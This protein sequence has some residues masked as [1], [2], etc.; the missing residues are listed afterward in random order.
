MF[1]HAIV[2]SRND[3]GTLAL[4]IT[5]VLVNHADVVHVLNHGSSDQTAHGLKVLQEIWGKR[6][7]IY[8]A[9]PDIPF[10]QSLLTNMLVPIAENEGADWIYVFDSD[11]FL[12]SKPDFSLK[13]ELSKLSSDTVAARYNLSNYISTHD[14]D[15]DNISHYQ[16]LIYKSKPSINCDPIRSMEL[17]SEGKIS[18]FD[19]TF[20]S[21]IFFRANKDLLIAK[22]AHG[23]Q[24][25]LDKQSTISFIDAECAHLSLSSKK[26]LS[27]KSLHGKSLIDLGLSKKLGWQNQLVHQLDIAG[28]LD[29]FWEK[30]SIN[31]DHGEISNP[32]H[33]IDLSFVKCLSSSIE[34]LKEKFGGIDISMVSGTPLKTGCDE[35][36][37]FTFGSVF[38]M[39]D[40]FD[41][42]IQLFLRS[43]QDK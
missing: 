12:L 29:W 43:N 14:F 3:W 28:K 11:E 39:C 9:S 23:L 33:T 25:I 35:D 17:I 41:K 19:L 20:P 40:F 16:K 10:N 24:Y 7:K 2:V 1:I 27:V 30:H 6:L 34:I 32:V 38:Q 5:N 18:F 37:E 26:I 4:S 13:K 15:Q 42:K 36:T 8:S 22:G 21:K 31:T